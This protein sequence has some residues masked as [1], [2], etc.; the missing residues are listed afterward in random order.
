MINNLLSF[1]SMLED[2]RRYFAN[3]DGA[4]NSCRT[5]ALWITIALVLAFAVTKI[6]T[7]VIARKKYGA[8]SLEKTNS[9]INGIWIAIAIVFASLF[10]ITFA[11]C[12]FV[13]VAKGEEYLFP[14]LFCPLLVLAIA[15][16]ASATAIAIKPVKLTKII[17][18][19][20]CGAALI[21]VIVCMIVYYASGD[22][23]EAL[24]SLGLYLSAGVLIAGTIALAFFSD[25]N[26]KPFNARSIAFAAVSVALSFALSYVRLF[27]MPMGGSITF[28]S[29]LPLMLY[30][31]MFGSRKGVIAGLVL[32]LLQAIQDP[33]IIHPAQFALDYAIAF[34]AI[35]LTGC[36][37]GFNLF[38]GKIRSQFTLGAVIAGVLR[39]ISH[40]F[41]GVF[42]FGAYGAGYAEDYGISLLANEYFYSLVYQSLY[43]IPEVIIVTVVGVL[44][45][46]SG[47]FRKQVE[48]YSDFK[49]EQ[50]T[51]LQILEE[52]A[53]TQDVAE[54]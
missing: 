48:K 31:F 46:T 20:V 29:M 3:F 1:G 14:I 27:R 11:T 33:W 49:T 34:A 24:S 10:I 12:Y 9:V 19:S 22:A 7:F 32:G 51:E 21:A 2:T 38:K 47:N 37:R 35:G 54:Q 5:V 39:F 40:Y 15:V 53:A 36:I 17:T 18:S 43:V 26:S 30:S 25:R 50:K 23:G 42:A 44:L 6:Y 13:E 45:L 28:A 41:S 52:V 16:V 4:T 8:E